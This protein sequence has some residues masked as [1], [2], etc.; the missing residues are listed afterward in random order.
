[1]TIQAFNEG[2]VMKKRHFI[3]IVRERYSAGLTK[4]WLNAF[5]GRHLD[6]LQICSSPPQEDAYLLVP[7]DLL[8]V[9]LRT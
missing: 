2:K 4:G 7:R 5:V 3:E 8:G 6:T 1:M 9:T